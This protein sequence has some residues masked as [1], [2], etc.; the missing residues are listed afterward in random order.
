[1]KTERQEFDEF[2][3]GV[4]PPALRKVVR[5]VN[6]LMYQCEVKMQRGHDECKDSTLSSLSRPFGIYPKGSVARAMVEYENYKVNYP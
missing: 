6:S 4:N 3:K 5:E 1:M 2:L